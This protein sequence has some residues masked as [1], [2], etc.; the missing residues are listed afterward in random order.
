MIK[1]V[2]TLAKLKYQK[3]ISDKPE[4]TKISKKYSHIIYV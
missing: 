2:N 3:T 4:N 1:I